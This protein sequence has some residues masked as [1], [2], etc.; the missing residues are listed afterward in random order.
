MTDKSIETAKVVATGTDNYATF[1]GA[2]IIH[3]IADGD[4]FID[5]NTPAVTS[6]S[7]LM[8]ANSEAHPFEVHGGS[9]NTVHVITSGATVN[10]YLVAVY[11]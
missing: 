3:A 8:K 1:S 7:F 5:F 11:N 10:V 6:R 4:C 9:I 2:Q